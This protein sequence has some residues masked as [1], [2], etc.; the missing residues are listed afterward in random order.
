MAK[1]PKNDPKALIAA[2]ESDLHATS[3]AD[4]SGLVFKGL[5]VDKQILFGSANLRRSDFRNAKLRAVGFQDSDLSDSDFSGATLDGS[6]STS[7]KFVRV[8]L[9][10]A[11]IHQSLFSGADFTEV[12]ARGL[13][14]EK[15][16]W[17]SI[18]AGANLQGARL[19]DTSSMGTDARKADFSKADLSKGIYQ[20]TDFRDARL[21]DADLT[22]TEWDKC[23][24][25][26]ADLT[27]ATLAKAK[28]S[29]CL[30]DER[31]RWPGTAPKGAVWK[32]KGKPPAGAASTPAPGL[33]PAALKPIGEVSNWGDP[34]LISDAAAAKGWKGAGPDG[35]S[36]EYR[37]ACKAVSKGSAASFAF[38]DARGI[39]WDVQGEGTAYV[40][41]VE[42]GLML[43]RPWLGDGDDEAEAAG[44]L[45]A[46]PPVKAKAAGMHHF[47]S[48]VVAVLGSAYDAGR[49]PIKVSKKGVAA[50]GD[51][52][53]ALLV[54]LPRGKYRLQ[55]DRVTRPEGEAIRLFLT[56]A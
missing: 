21:I 23:D 37:R 40:F 56:R 11:R 31:T 18:L 15:T 7:A 50:H 30:W 19:K 27:G 43:V 49:L 24:F 22:G 38:G 13:A 20:E 36:T 39:L 33:K 52:S 17:P 54:A 51:D 16:G 55:S 29:K 47:S 26:G 9:E 45:A 25:R 44:I 32:G 34:L 2:M 42:G 8:N 5:T 53:E 14:L 46:L 4:L 35:K 48:D 3:G 1:L 12:R 41:R 6:Y 10:G 28:F